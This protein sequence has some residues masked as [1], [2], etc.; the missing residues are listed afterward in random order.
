MKYVSQA[1]CHLAI[2]LVHR[3]TIA[4]YRIPTVQRTFIV[5][6]MDR[7]HHNDEQNWTPFGQIGASSDRR[8]LELYVSQENFWNY[9]IAL[10]VEFSNG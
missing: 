10:E 9:F 2:F 1:L 4:T 8:K 5:M 7:S 6:Y 3:F